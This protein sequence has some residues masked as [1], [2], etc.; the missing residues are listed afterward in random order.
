MTGRRLVLNDGTQIE[1]GEA[2]YADG[3]LWLYLPEYTIQQG[4]MFF[5]PSKTSKIVFQYGEME[6]TYTGFITC[7][8]LMVRDNILSVQLVQEANNA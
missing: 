7:K 1:N 4:V 5:D 3:F 2:G 6:D 8:T